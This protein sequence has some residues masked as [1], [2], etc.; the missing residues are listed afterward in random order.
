MYR[1]G[2]IEQYL[3]DAASSKPAPGGGSVSALAGTL[4][5]AMGAMAANFTVGKRKFADVEPRVKELLAALLRE[6]EELLSLV[7]ED[8]AAYGQLSRAYGLPKDSEQDKRERAQAIQQAL[9]VALAVPR[10]IVKSCSA[11]L[12]ILTELVDL[13]NPNLISDVGVAAV[14]AQ[15]AL[16]G[17]KLNVEI[18]LASLK[19]QHLV[20]QVRQEIGAAATAASQRAGEV[21]RKARAAI[22]GVR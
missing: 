17:G 18:N 3:A 4:G 11:V 20:D 6:Q 22:I 12:E 16:E 9:V 5:T 13:A 8:V 1:K 19:D 7:D 2:S 21:L 14:L 15:A 10:R